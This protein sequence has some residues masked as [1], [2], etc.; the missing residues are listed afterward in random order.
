[1]SWL[2]FLVLCIVVEVTPGPNMGYLTSLSLA[3]GRRA[4]L[5]TVAGVAAG[6]SVHAVAAAFGLGYLVA[7]SPIVYETL[8]WGGIA[9]LVYLAIDGWREAGSGGADAPEAKAG[10]HFL[11]GFVTNVLN[12]KSVL[13]F[14]T[15]VPRFVDPADPQ[16]VLRLALL[17]ATYV[18]V[19][20]A[21][22][23]ALVLAAS[24]GERLLSASP[25]RVLVQRLLALSLIPIAV[26]LAFGTAR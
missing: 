23:T 8:R 14:V 9:F 6:L 10:R 22:H 13:F 24:T 15:V 25:R 12:P 4:G 16:P 5:L 17:G 1:M 11:R 18:T 7:A 21:V 2:E 20:T 3:K 19:A 26:W